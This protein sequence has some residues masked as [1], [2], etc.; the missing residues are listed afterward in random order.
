MI[1]IIL[2]QQSKMQLLNDMTINENK[3][4]NVLILDCELEKYDMRN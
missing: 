2:V 3:E 4:F 1:V